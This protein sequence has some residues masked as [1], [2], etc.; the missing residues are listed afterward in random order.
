MDRRNFLMDNY[1]YYSSKITIYLSYPYHY[2]PLLNHFTICQR[3]IYLCFFV[4]QPADLSH[5]CSF[6]CP[7]GTYSFRTHW[8]SGTSANLLPE[9]KAPLRGTRHSALIFLIA[10]CGLRIYKNFHQHSEPK[11]PLWGTQH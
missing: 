9:P 7:F 1:K 5:L 4:R 10:D 8:H 6:L 11:A 3:R 2:I